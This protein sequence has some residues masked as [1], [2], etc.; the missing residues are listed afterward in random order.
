MISTSTMG[1]FMCNIVFFNFW[2]GS[3][4]YCISD[5]ICRLHV[6]ECQICI[7][8][9]KNISLTRASQNGVVN[10]TIKAN[11]YKNRNEH[12]Y[13]LLKG[14]QGITRYAA[15][16][17]VE[18]EVLKLD[19]NHQMPRNANVKTVKCRQK[20]TGASDCSRY[21]TKIRT[22]HHDDHRSSRLCTMW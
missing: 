4:V 19:Q 3:F 1:P 18:V 15:H 16:A 2:F 9:K 7:R 6:L 14:T 8:T 10:N 22:A 11:L 5:L 17:S 12:I 13:L 20:N 21:F